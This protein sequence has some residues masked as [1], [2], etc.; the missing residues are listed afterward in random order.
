[1]LEIHAFLGNAGA[2]ERLNCTTIVGRFK[3]SGKR[4]STK[5][6]HRDLTYMRRVLKLPIDY[7]FV[8]HSYAYTQ[9]DVAFPVGPDLSTAERIALIVAR[10]AL[11]VFRGV[12]FAALVASAYEKLFGAYGTPHGL[13][14]AGNLE[15]YLSVRTPGAGIVDKKVFLAVVQALLGRRELR[16]DYQSSAE[17][18]PARRRL[19]PYHLACVDSRWVLVARNLEKDEIRTYVL[20]RF[21]KP[22]VTQTSFE[23]PENLDIAAR[24]ATSFGVWTGQGTQRVQLRFAPVAAHHVLERHWHDTQR[25]ERRADGGIDVTFALSDLNDITRWILGFGGDV[26]VIAPPE[27]RATIAAEGRR[28]MEKHATR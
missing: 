26:D 10:Q 12:N 20:A 28:M 27:L 23:R 2:G 13:V 7:D 19:A 24:L 21:S 8:Q 3:E 4:V 22:L 17:T 11:G 14:L 15:D 18:T 16:I 5:T 6:V 9:P 1:M 25:V